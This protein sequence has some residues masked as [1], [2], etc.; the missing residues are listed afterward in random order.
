M[1]VALKRASY[2]SCGILSPG[3]SLHDFICKLMS[4]HTLYVKLPDLHIVVK[5]SLFA[6]GS[7]LAQFVLCPFVITPFLRFVKKAVTTS[8]EQKQLARFLK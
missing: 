7:F 2:G 5:C 6:H 1:L 4:Q 8:F 3:C